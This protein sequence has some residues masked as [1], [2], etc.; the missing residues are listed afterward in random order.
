MAKKKA[1]KVVNEVIQD[2]SEPKPSKRI[3]EPKAPVELD[4]FSEIRELGLG[5][6]KTFEECKSHDAALRAQVALNRKF[7]ELKEC[8]AKL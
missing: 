7:D 4:S 8:L 2:F 3:L 5:L 1:K 6:C